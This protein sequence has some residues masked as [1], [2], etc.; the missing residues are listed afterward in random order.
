MLA[1]VAC[2]ALPLAAAAQGTLG[3]DPTQR[4]GEPSP[5]QREQL[6]PPER[7]PPILPPIPPTPPVTAPGADTGLRVLVRDLRFEG[8]TVFQDGAL[9]QVVAGYLGRELT[10]EDLETIRVALTVHYVNAGYVNSG[11]VLPDQTIEDGV[12]T[13]RIV[14]G[15]LTHIDVAPTRWFR[16]R[17]LRRRVQLGAG[18]P[19]NV[20]D[21]QERLQ[22]L[23]QDPR[24]ERLDAELRPGLR[25]GDSVLDLRVE[26][27]VPYRLLLEVN[28]HQ[29]P[30]IG[31]ERGTV[32]LEHLNLTGHGDVLTL[33]YGHSSGVQPLLD[34]RYIV[35]IT[36]WDTTVGLQYRRTDFTVIEEPFAP[37]D[38]ESQSE[39]Y[40]LSLR[41]PL[42]RTLRT[43]LAAGL[44]LEHLRNETT[45]LG[46][47]FTLS[48]GAEDGKSV[49]TALR[50][51]VEFLDRTQDH[52]IALRSQ[53]S[54]GLP[55]LGA[56]VADSGDVADGKFF[57]WLGQAQYVRRLP[58]WDAQAILR[59]DVQLADEPL[60]ALEQISLG[61]RY[62]VRG[63]R[64]NTLIRDN[65]VLASVEVRVPVVSNRPWADVLEVAPFVDWGH[66]F[67]HNRPPPD[68]E[69]LVSA[70]VGL[71][72]ALSA[73]LFG[74]LPSRTAFEVYWG[75]R[76]RSTG[77]P[78]NGNLQDHGL[79]FQLVF[80]LF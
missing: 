10:A 71:R 26:E 44:A 30:S 60:L 1:A 51:S 79:H 46:R 36:P 23:Q 72:W 69:H 43:E 40:T 64:E 38:I 3:I 9:R 6:A 63:Y 78:G 62:T 55:V 57:S 50:A 8:N 31:S 22:F 47:P 32:T 56:T 15:Q 42:Y 24:V 80:G 18:P 67:N 12:V 54:F 70:G 59:T 28:N 52:V 29:S 45:L 65:A 17:F 25:A 4:S 7:R 77:E 61:G 2:L 14:E 11:A 27:R 76:L 73:N 16:E 21:L 41:H 5:L 75:K 66:G 13:Y 68:S 33:R 20:Y 49:V 35:P 53:F 37:L 58:W 34:F 74:R 39:I 19:L 48:P